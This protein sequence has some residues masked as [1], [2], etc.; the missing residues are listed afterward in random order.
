MRSILPLHW[1]QLLSTREGKGKALKTSPP[2][3]MSRKYASLDSTLADVHNNVLTELQWKFPP[4]LLIFWLLVSLVWKHLHFSKS[5]CK[6]S[7]F[8]GFALEEWN[9]RKK[10]HNTCFKEDGIFFLPLSLLCLICSALRCLQI[11]Q[12]CYNRCLT[13]TS[14][15]CSRSKQCW[16]WSQLVVALDPSS[17]SSPQGLL[18]VPWL[19]GNVIQ[20]DV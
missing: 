14:A 4:V 15:R 20:A 16:A 10:K 9:S 7:I 1:L 13:S 18:S 5:A 6:L 3:H 2:L 19:L 11:N 17:V 12:G 8:S